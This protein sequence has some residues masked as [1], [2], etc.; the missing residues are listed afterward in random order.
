[1]GY[2]KVKGKE[3]IKFRLNKKWISPDDTQKVEVNATVRRMLKD[4]DLIEV[5]EQPSKQD[6]HS[7]KG[8]K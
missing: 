7:R 4:G 6:K 1:M 3:G 2:V 5:V 8:G